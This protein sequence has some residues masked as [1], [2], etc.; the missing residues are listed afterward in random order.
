MDLN[1]SYAST[2]AWFV[3]LAVLFPANSIPTLDSSFASTKCAQVLNARNARQI[4]NF[5]VE[6]H[7]DVDRDVDQDKDEYNDGAFYEQN[8]D[9]KMD[10]C[11]LDK[12][13]S[14]KENR[15]IADFIATGF[16]IARNEIP[17]SESS[18]AFSP[19]GPAKFENLDPCV[20]VRN[21][22]QCRV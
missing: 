2:E 12:P 20:Y 19:E 4:A 22:E 11:S 13:E 3:K 5:D 15:Q 18:S 10:H 8:V 17:D 21:C 9:L 7:Q 6:F 14:A 1:A 16:V